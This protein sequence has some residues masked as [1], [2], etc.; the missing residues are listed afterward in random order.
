MRYSILSL[1]TSERLLELSVGFHCYPKVDHKL[2]NWLVVR[3]IFRL[4]FS[5]LGPKTKTTIGEMYIIDSK[6]VMKVVSV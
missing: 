2:V 6:L 1:Y 3:L 4:T 5:V